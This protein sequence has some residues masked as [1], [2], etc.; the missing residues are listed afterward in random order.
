[1]VEMKTCKCGHLEREDIHPVEI[2]EG[3]H[4]TGFALRESVL[5]EHSELGNADGTARNIYA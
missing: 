5:A 1:M 3:R 4:S 2:A